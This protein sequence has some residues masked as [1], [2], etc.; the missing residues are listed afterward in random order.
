MNSCCSA[1]HPSRPRGIV[2][3]D[4]CCCGVFAVALYLSGSSVPCREA[5]HVLR[6]SWCSPCSIILTNIRKLRR[7][8][9][10]GSGLRD[11]LVIVK[12]N[13]LSRCG[14]GEGAASRQ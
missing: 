11:A 9:I 5:W 10:T 6:A 3:R 14:R 1:L 13:D 4:R 12:D 2:R 7:A 8:G